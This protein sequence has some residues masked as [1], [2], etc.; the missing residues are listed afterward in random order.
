MPYRSRSFLVIALLCFRGTADFAL[1]QVDPELAAYAASR[2]KV[3]DDLSRPIAE[4][5]GVA[6]EVAATLDRAAWATNSLA[7]RRSDWSEARSVLDGF[8]S[9]NP[10]HPQTR[11]L[12]FQGAVYLWAEGQSWSRGAEAGDPGARAHAASAFDDAIARLR[13]LADALSESDDALAQNTRYRLARALLDRSRLDPDRPAAPT[14]RQDALK[15]VE[16]RPFSEKNLLGFAELLRA[17]LLATVGRFEE[18]RNALKASAKAPSPPSVAERL[19]ISVP[20]ASGLKEFAASKAEIDASHLPIVEKNRLQLRLLLAERSKLDPG[21][22]RGRVEAECFRLVAELKTIDPVESAG[23]VRELARAIDEPSASLGPE[24]WALLAEGSLAVNQ[25]DRASRLDVIAAAKAEGHGDLDSA[26]RWRFRAGAV[27]YEAGRFGRADSL[28]SRILEDKEAGP[29]RPRAG[30]L[31]ALSRGRGLA[32]GEVGSS[33]SG[34]LAALIEQIHDFPDDPSTGE[35]RWLLGRV[36][37]EEGGRAETERLW[38]SI[39]RTHARWLDSRLGLIGLMCSDLEEKRLVDAP[40]SLH[41]QAELVREAIDA[42]RRESRDESERADLD[43]ERIRLELIPGVGDPKRGFEAVER[44]RALPLSRDQRVRTDT[45]RIVGLAA[46]EKFLEAERVA[47]DFSGPFASRLALARDLDRW[48]S[49]I[50]PERLARRIGGVEKIIADR[51]EKLTDSAPEAS[52]EVRLRRAR[53]RMHAGDMA[54][55]REVVKDW[56]DPVTQLP[57]RLADLADLLAQLDDRD[58]AI[59]AYRLLARKT[60]SG[61]PR[62]LEARLGQARTLAEARQ[63]VSARQILEGTAL[64]HPDLGGPVMRDQFAALKSKLDRR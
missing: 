11:L 6:L 44:L 45:L 59:A 22:D 17:D 4:R 41:T 47:A 7:T 29:L 63:V 31:R 2:R 32:A 26:R 19:A 27:S 20:I 37:L 21:T 58:Q 23:A 16:A 60:T 54:G 40:Q 49:A 39:P 53:S 38:G 34:F 15:I 61:S 24:A 14:L 18:A 1:G 30:M 13:P 42:A 35:A 12:A 10:G 9:R 33:R 51:M 64:L 52:A 48:A 8:S 36:R 5:E 46:N 43:L 28:F 56:A 62:W 55:A 57:G 50:R 3:M 25:P